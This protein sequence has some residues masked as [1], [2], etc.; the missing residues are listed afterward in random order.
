MTK[1][2][3]EEW[4]MIK[5]LLEQ[6]CC[7]SGLKVNLN[8]STF[9]HAGIQGEDLARFKDIFSYN[10]MELSGGFRYLGY[11]IKAEKTSLKTGDG[12]S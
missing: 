11:F 12:L 5:T 1:A 10:F 7:A 8:K 6:F 2:S 4:M 3:I 9:H